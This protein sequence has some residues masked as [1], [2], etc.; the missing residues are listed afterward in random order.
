MSTGPARILSYYANCS[1]G[2]ITSVYRGRALRNPDVQFD[3]VFSADRDGRSAFTDLPNVDVRIVSPKKLVAY[4]NRVVSTVDYS[5]V[6]ICTHKDLPGQLKAPVGTRVIYEVHSPMAK[7]VLAE[8]GGLDVSAVDE[9]WAPS[10]WAAELVRSSLPRRRHVPV[11]V[12][13]NPVDTSRFTTALDSRLPLRRTGEVPVLWIGRFENQHKNYIDFLRVLKLLPEEFYGIMIVSLE[14]DPERFS[15]PILEASML[16]VEDRLDLHLNIAQQDVADLHRAVAA[17]GG[18]YC[19]TALY[20]TYGYAVVEASLCGVPVVA[21]QVGPL[22][23]HQ[24]VRYR[25]VPV[26]SVKELA[27]AIVEESAEAG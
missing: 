9:V 25:L 4:L 12:R 13:P 17:A 8:L 2:G 21:Y 1:L 6:R 15:R 14:E 7:T 19:S 26:G 18:V 27:R 16:G 22:T 5:E 20:E 11:R 3:L 23:D 24:L 10:E